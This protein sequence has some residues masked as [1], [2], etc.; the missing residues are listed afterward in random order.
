MDTQ[1]TGS[2]QARADISGIK[3]AAA[4]LATWVI[5]RAIQ[6]H[7]GAGVSNDFPLAA[8]YAYART[9]HIVD[10]AD[11]VHKMVIAREEL[12]RWR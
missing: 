4:D 2:Q 6:V 1:G 8:M 5:D 3:V 12:G 9:L 10:G 11:E 7:G